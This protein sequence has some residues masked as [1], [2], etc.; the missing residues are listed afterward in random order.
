MPTSFR[1]PLECE[2]LVSSRSGNLSTV[3][4]PAGVV[5]GEAAVLEMEQACDVVR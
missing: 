2:G 3:N 1:L 5:E 4:E